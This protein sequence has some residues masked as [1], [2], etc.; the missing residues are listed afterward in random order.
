MLL[1]LHTNTLIYRNIL[2]F[3]CCCSSTFS[4]FLHVSLFPLNGTQWDMS[5]FPPTHAV[6]TLNG[7]PTL[8]RVLSCCTISDLSPLVF[9]KYL[10][11]VNIFDTCSCWKSLS[12]FDPRRDEITNTCLD[13]LSGAELVYL[14]LIRGHESQKFPWN[15]S[16]LFFFFF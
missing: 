7:S 1:P 8:K 4:Y 9:R 10:F 2:L 12:V 13:C 15:H 3:F 16:G 11:M 5:M 14:L 6:H